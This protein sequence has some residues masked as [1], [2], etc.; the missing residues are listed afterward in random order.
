MNTRRSILGYQ[1]NAIKPNK[2]YIAISMLQ[3]ADIF[4]A[5][6]YNWYWTSMRLKC[7]Q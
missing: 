4:G 1:L 7:Y 6:E 2:H 3:P 5:P